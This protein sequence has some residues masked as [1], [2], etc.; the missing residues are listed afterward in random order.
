MENYGKRQDWPAALALLRQMPIMANRPDALCYHAAISA[1]E[2]GDQWHHA[3]S[4]LKE[5]FQEML[6]PDPSC[7]IT[8][9]RACE[10]AKHWSGILA[11]FREMQSKGIDV[12][13]HAKSYSAALSG[14][15]SG[16]EW[17]NALGML[18]ELVQ[19]L[20]KPDVLS[21]NAVIKD[22]LNGNFW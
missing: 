14:C 8:A 7:C 12:R 20:F 4:L 3:L 21:Y 11:L 1:C 15:T 19:E 10:K 13:H 17:V 9:I 5:M 2:K 22:S 6:R 16:H 18:D